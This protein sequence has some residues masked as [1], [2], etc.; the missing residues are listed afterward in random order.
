MTVT[1]S[2]DYQ[3]IF[4]HAPI[5]MCVSRFRIIHACN[6]MLAQIF[7]Y[8]ASLLIDQSFSVLYPTFDEFECTGARIMKRVGLGL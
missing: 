1:A 8:V 3:D 5:G 6:D 4:M 7:G 2:I